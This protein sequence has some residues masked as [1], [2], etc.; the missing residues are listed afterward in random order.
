M[1]ITF[2]WG[3]ASPNVDST[4]VLWVGAQFSHLQGLATVWTILFKPDIRLAFLDTVTC[5]R[6][7][8]EDTRRTE[9]E[10]V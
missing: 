2:I 3:P 9:R 8:N 5:G 1:I 6:Y 7:N 4:W 10:R